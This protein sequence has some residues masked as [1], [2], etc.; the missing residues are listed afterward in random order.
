MVNRDEKT[1]RVESSFVSVDL[2]GTSLNEVE[3][4]KFKIIWMNL[5][6][7][8]SDKMALTHLT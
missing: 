8:F 5:V 2:D 3:K 1:L 7:F 4:V 6:R